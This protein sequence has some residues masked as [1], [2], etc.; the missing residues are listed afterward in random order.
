MAAAQICSTVQTRQ[1][2]RRVGRAASEWAQRSN[3]TCQ[4]FSQARQS[5]SP[6]PSLPPR[7]KFSGIFFLDR[8]SDPAKSVKWRCREGARKRTSNFSSRQ[9]CCPYR[10]MC[11]L[12]ERGAVPSGGGTGE[13]EV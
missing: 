3:E 2:K 13:G 9:S 6:L 10:L 1:R 4:M 5:D 8:T 12:V 11:L 7:L